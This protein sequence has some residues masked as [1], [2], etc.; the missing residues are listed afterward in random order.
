MLQ[1]TREAAHMKMEVDIFTVY[2]IEQK[3]KWVNM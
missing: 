1:D 3:S 2:D